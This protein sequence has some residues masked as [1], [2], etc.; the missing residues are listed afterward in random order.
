MTLPVTDVRS[1]PQDQIA[2]AVKVLGRSKDRLAVFLKLHHG[3]KK[4]KTAT[5][6]SHLTGLDRKRVLE[7][8]KLLVHKQLIKQTERDDDVAYERDG[9]Y[10]AHRRQ[11]FSLVK[12]PK[13]FKQFPTKYSPRISSARVSISLPKS[14][15]RTATITVDD[16]DSFNKVRRVK[17]A[18][19]ISSMLENRF[20]LGVKR[21]LG[22]SGHFKDWGGES[23][24]LYS[25]RLK[26]KGSRRYAAIAFKGRGTRGILTPAR[27]GKNGD[28]IQRLF[29]EDGEIF[30]VQYGQQI[31]P[32]ILHQMAVFAQAKSIAT[33]K[34]V[35]YGIIDG[36]DSSR[37]V[38]AYPKAFRSRK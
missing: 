21:I 13:K 27:M 16:I 7:E 10:Y 23:S 12:N 18:A 31:A 20:K 11:I 17:N 25:T 15:I 4:I 14:L 2:H 32:S 8:G 26:M 22:E 35:F 36:H 33:G 29:M 1:N 28:Q 6:L 5:E 24:D 3:R 19:T 34:K 37:I 9:F 30:L 38:A